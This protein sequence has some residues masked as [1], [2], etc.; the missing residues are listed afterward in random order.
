VLKTQI[1]G[2]GEGEGVSLSHEGNA[3]F[4]DALSVTEVGK[5]T[6]KKWDNY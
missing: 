1:L 3:L 6:E 5:Y 2:E 4:E